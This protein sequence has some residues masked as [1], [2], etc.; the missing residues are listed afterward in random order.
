MLLE[1]AAAFFFFALGLGVIMLNVVGLIEY[2]RN[3]K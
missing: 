1:L 3:V 2:I